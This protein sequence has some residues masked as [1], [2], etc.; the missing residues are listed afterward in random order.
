MRAH[1][2]QGEIASADLNPT[3]WRTQLGGGFYE[4]FLK[5][6][7]LPAQDIKNFLGKNK[8]DA[9]INSAWRYTIQKIIT[10]Y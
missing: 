6:V 7:P 10:K 2:P 8:R 5:K 4:P 9:E 1:L 3:A